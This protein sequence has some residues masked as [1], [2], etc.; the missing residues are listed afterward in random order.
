M[1]GRKKLGRTKKRTR[2][3]SKNRRGS[4]TPRKSKNRPFYSMTQQNK[5]NLFRQH[6]GA[7][8]NLSRQKIKNIPEH[9]GARDYKYELYNDAKIVKNYCDCNKN[10]SG[11]SKVEL[12]KY[13]VDNIKHN[14]GWWKARQN[15]KGLL[16]KPVDDYG[17]KF[18]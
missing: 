8:R 1:T 7:R 18:V 12:K 4:S 2:R 5:N 10:I 6:P 17:V 13:I 11:M 9:P 14:T 16:H 15:K 3:K